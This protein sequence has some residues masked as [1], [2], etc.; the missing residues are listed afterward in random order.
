MAKNNNIIKYRNP[1]NFNIGVVIFLIIIIYVAFNVFSYFTKD[2]IAEYRVQQG[3]IASN[4]VYQGVIVRDETIEYA[5]KDGYVD[6]YIKNG[7]KV[8]VTDVI[9]SIDT[10]GNISNAIADA[11]STSEELSKEALESIAK[12]ID[13]FLESYDADKFNTS[14]TF[15]NDLHS[16]IVYSI[17]SNALTGL[18]DKVNQA[19]ANDTFF[20]FSSPSDGVILYEIDGLEGITADSLI[21]SGFDTSAYQK[22]YL[23]ANRKVTASAPVYKRVNSEKWEIVIPIEE[24]L[25]KELNE[26]KSITIRFCKD[27]FQTSASCSVLKKNG[28]YYLKLSLKTG[29]I[30]YI[31]DRFIDVELVMKTTTGLKIPVSAITS[32]EFF[33]VPKE[34]FT[35]ETDG[36]LV[37]S[38]DKDSKKEIITQVFPTIYYAAEEYYYIDS[39]LV[40]AGDTILMPESS[41]TY[42]IGTDTDSLIG[43]YNINKGYAVFKQINI[44]YQNEDYAIVENKTSYGISLYDHIALDASTIQEHQLIT[45]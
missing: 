29:M 44:L 34:F 36:L 37:K 43:V 5:A 38:Y 35:E 25:A 24:S 13:N 40:S 41:A 28:D 15:F 22:Q 3:S 12:E 33:T 4:Y 14:Y 30:R 16:E 23:T 32:K 45:Q 8:S 39:E 26:K 9:Y 17:N 1:V 7:S 21:E 6:Y 20:K 31:E 18:E 42:V 11:G 10:I 2:D 27:N 19:E